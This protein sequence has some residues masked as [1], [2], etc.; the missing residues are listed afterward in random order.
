MHLYPRRYLSKEDKYQPLTMCGSVSLPGPSVEVILLVSFGTNN[1]ESTHNDGPS[2]LCNDFK[3]CVCVHLCSDAC[4]QIP[5][6]SPCDRRGCL[7][8]SKE[9]DIQ[10]KLKRFLEIHPITKCTI[11]NTKEGLIFLFGTT[12]NR[13]VYYAPCVPLGLMRRILMENH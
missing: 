5:S 13:L 12:D 7:V 10:F 11:W 4:V 9:S 3:L 8:C 6:F 2:C 1:W